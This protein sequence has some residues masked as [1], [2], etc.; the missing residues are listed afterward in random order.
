MRALVTGGAGF[1]GRHLCKG[2]LDGGW[3]V[4]CVD[5]VVARTGGLPPDAW[6]LFDPRDYTNFSYVDMDCR[7]YFKQDKSFDYLFH[8]AAMVGGRLMIEYDPLAVAEDLAID[9]EFFRYA[10]RVK[11]H[12]SVFFSSSAAYPVS[13]QR[14]DNFVLLRE[15]MIEFENTIGV[16]DLSYGWAKLTGEYLARLAH[17]RYQQNVVCYRPFSGYGE[18]QDLTYPFPSICRRAIEQR[19]STRDCS[20][21]HWRSDARLHPYQRLREFYPR[22]NGPDQRR[23]GAEPVFRPADAVQATGQDGGQR[24]GVRPGC[25]RHLQS[26]GRCVRSRWRPHPARGAWLDAADLARGGGRPR[27]G[28]SGKAAVPGGFVGYP[29]RP[30]CAGT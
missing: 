11:P 3:E 10:V 28:L 16:P 22:L 5:P 29:S 1:V 13:L 20:L 30:H 18:D 17:Q 14:R 25:G 21:G 24:G 27:R 6:P 15:D 4:V 7:D 12:K 19:G 26:A 9:A 2:L 8:L 23:F